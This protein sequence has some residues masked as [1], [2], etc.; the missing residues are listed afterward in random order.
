MA[1]KGR[2]GPAKGLFG[3]PIEALVRIE[4]VRIARQAGGVADSLRLVCFAVLE[5][6]GSLSRLSGF[7]PRRE[8]RFSSPGCGGTGAQTLEGARVRELS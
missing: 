8:V 3:L 7:I 5:G 6:V 4:F 1:R 2:A